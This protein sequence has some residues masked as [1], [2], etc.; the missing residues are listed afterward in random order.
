MKSPVDSPDP[1]FEDEKA[2]IGCTWADFSTSSFTC[3][4]PVP[5]SLLASTHSSQNDGVTITESGGTDYD[6]WQNFSDMPVAKSHQLS[7]L[8]K[9]VMKS[10]FETKNEIYSCELESK[11]CIFCD[12]R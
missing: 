10:C 3:T 11:C 12:H 6:D 9:E 2:S 8:S 5:A 7:K 1:T 4:Q